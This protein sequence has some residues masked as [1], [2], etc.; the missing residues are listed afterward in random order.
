MFNI[1]NSILGGIS[2][3]QYF[4]FLKRPKSLKKNKQNSWMVVL[5]LMIVGMMGFT[6]GCQPDPTPTPSSSSS[7]SVNVPVTPVFSSNA[8]QFSVHDNPVWLSNNSIGITPATDANGDTITYSI[9]TDGNESNL[10]TINSDNAVIKVTAGK[11]L[12][13]SVTNLHQII[14]RASDGLLGTE[15]G[16][17]VE[18]TANR[19]PQLSSDTFNAPRGISDTAVIGTVDAS[20]ADGDPITYRIS[21]SSIFEITSDGSIGLMSGSTLTNNAG[22]DFQITVQASDGNLQAEALITI[23]VYPNQAPVIANTQTVFTVCSNISDTNIIGTINASDRD[24]DPIDYN[25]I[26]DGADLFEIDAM[27]RISLIDDLSFADSKYLIRV[28]ATDGELSD[29]VD[30]DINVVICSNSSESLIL[31]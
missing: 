11:V 5:L 10:F 2:V 13:A 17:M 15:V 12:D 21:G 18:V 22:E 19:S 24:L 25:I 20:D 6:G 9:L 27:G 1:L 29:T 7:P 8:Y 3:P 31:F 16:V 30:L 23:S 14:V 26:I 4:I 28:E